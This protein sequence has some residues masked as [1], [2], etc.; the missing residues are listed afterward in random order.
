M[1]GTLAW[2]LP[3]PEC[4]G[5]RTCAGAAGTEK[6]P[7]PCCHCFVTQLL[8]PININIQKSRAC[9]AAHI[10]TAASTLSKCFRYPSIIY[11]VTKSFFPGTS[12]VMLLESH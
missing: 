9:C 5:T 12:S 6:P 11:K 7:L 8:M 2:A 4:M 10:P 1:A 3:G